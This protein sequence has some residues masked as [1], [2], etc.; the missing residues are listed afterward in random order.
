MKIEQ[1]KV[2]V[3]DTPVTVIDPNT[4]TE[5]AGTVKGIYEDKFGVIT[6]TALYQ[7]PATTQFQLKDVNP[8]AVATV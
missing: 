5:V 2:L 7:T 4:N 1:A 8:E 6:V 3:L